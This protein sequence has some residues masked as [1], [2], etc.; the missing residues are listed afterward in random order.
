MVLHACL[1]PNCALATIRNLHN[2]VAHVYHCCIAALVC[3]APRARGL[4][5][6]ERLMRWEWQHDQSRYNTTD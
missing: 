3:S 6:P 2:V 5:V 4:P 1:Q